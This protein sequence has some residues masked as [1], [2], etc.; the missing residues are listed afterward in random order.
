MECDDW[1]TCTTPPV[2][3]R[4]DHSDLPLEEFAAAGWFV[5]ASHGD[6]CPACVTAAG[7]M[8]TLT[9]KRVREGGPG[10]PHSL[11]GSA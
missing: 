7:G 8:D 4:P 9:A 11:M 6:L 5:A 3:P 2:G 1:A 10:R